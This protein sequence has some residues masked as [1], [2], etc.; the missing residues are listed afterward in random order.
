MERNPTGKTASTVGATVNHVTQGMLLQIFPSCN[1]NNNN[2][3][4]DEN[5]IQKWRLSRKKSSRSQ[6]VSENDITHCRHLHKS[7]FIW[8]YASLKVWLSCVC[9]IRYPGRRS[10]KIKLCSPIWLASRCLPTPAPCRGK[11]LLISKASHL[12]G[13][14]LPV[15]CSS[16]P[17]KRLS[18][19]VDWIQS[20]IKEEQGWWGWCLE[21]KHGNDMKVWRKTKPKNEACKAENVLPNWAF[22]LRL[23]ALHYKK[24]QL[25]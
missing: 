19:W 23:F 5:E 4:R 8:S 3:K 15:F 12:V 7:L 21:W 20:L 14:Q 2:K 11:V 6:L 17:G 9:C 18:L 24:F 1:E 22:G 13:F 25:L 10:E 16:G